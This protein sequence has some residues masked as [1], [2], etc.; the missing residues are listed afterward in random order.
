MARGEEPRILMNWARSFKSSSA[1]A[2]G[3]SVRWPDMSRKKRYSH[4]FVLAGRDSIL[5]WLTLCF[6]NGCSTR[7][8][9]P[10]PPRPEKR[11]EFLSS[12]VG[13]DA[14]F[15]RMMYRVKLF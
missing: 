3:G 4:A 11:I 7:Y 2:T 12:P 9:A 14:C 6:A 15:P 1:F 8:G 10:T 13:A 5:V